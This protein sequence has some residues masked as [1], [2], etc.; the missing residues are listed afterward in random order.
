LDNKNDL[1]TG[2]T[3][4]GIILKDS[5]SVVLAADMKAT[6]G[7]LNYD[8]E[9]QKIYKITDYL[10]VTNAGAVGDSLTIIRFLRS[11]ARIYEIE[12]ESKM[13]VKAA[14][15]FLSNVLNSNRYY[16]F[17]VQLLIGGANSKPELYELTP[18]GGM[19][20]RRQYGVSG[21]GTELALSVLDQ[22]YRPNLSEKEGI[23]L[24][25]EAVKAAKRRDV[26]SGGR[27]ISVMV[28]SPSGIRKVPEKDVEKLI[29]TPKQL[30]KGA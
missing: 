22:N 8:E 6:M 25:V 13:S 30:P 1:K 10:A 28:I 29:N 14:S 27:S 26:Y 21:S 24:A 23:A 19:L 18:Y 12:R 7:H 2:T 4:V 20:E 5:K 16:P 11:Q 3:T 17:S 15:T 9:S